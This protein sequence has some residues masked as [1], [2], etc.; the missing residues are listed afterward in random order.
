MKPKSFRRRLAWISVV[1]AALGLLAFMVVADRLWH[2]KRLQEIDGELARIGHVLASSGSTKQPWERVYALMGQVLGEEKLERRIL[3]VRRA[4][5]KGQKKEVY[6]SPN[7]PTTLSHIAFAASTESYEW[8]GEFADFY[9][10]GKFRRSRPTNPRRPPDWFIDRQGSNGRDRQEAIRT[11]GNNAKHL[12][13]KPQRMAAYHTALDQDTH[14]R[15]GVYANNDIDL[16]IGS[17]LTELRGEMAALRLT[18]LTATLGA[19]ALIGIGAWWL[20]R[21]ALRPIAALTYA[22]E[23]ISV[24]DLSQRIDLPDADQE[25]LPLIRHY[26][27]MMNRLETSFHQAT[28]FSAD[29]S[30]ELKTPLA[31]MKGTLERALTDPETRPYEQQ[32]YSNLLEEVEHQQAILQSLLLLS[33]AD[34]G[35]LNLNREP[36][37]FSQ[38]VQS[39]L[40]DA[41]MMADGME[42]TFDIE[43]SPDIIVSGDAA[44]L[45]QVVH[46]LLSNAL[47]YNRPTGRLRVRLQQAEPSAL[48]TVANTGE[49]IPPRANAQIFQRFYRVEDSRSHRTEGSGLGLS[50][51]LEI[52]RAHG[53]ELTLFSSTDKETVFVVKLPL[54]AL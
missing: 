4:R 34:S 38:L 46:N 20:S 48:L 13:R 27:A 21:K 47:K 43:I 28:R 44:L 14:W 31:I 32:Y 26:N 15:L 52:V 22:T 35:Q 39:A 42:L 10:P 29:A 49:P 18:A 36:L 41:E 19:L 54:I 53:G 5:T 24:N 8:E 23:S 17:S 9:R 33:R 50:L 16:V 25:F 11:R 3:T 30:H 12:Y 7:W 37:A 1:S 51:S 6:Q 45:G 40:E 2:R